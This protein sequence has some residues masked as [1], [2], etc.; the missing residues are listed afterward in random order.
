MCAGLLLLVF[1]LM[2]RDIAAY[3]GGDTPLMTILEIAGGL[4]L[5]FAG[6]KKMQDN[7]K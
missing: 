6:Y 3:I 5:I 2:K 1:G 7:N 4:Y